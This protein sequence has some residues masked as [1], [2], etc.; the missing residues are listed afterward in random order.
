MVAVGHVTYAFIRL[1]TIP[2]NC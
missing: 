1:V 2:R